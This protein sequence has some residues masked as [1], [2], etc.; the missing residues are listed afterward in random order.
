MGLIIKVVVG[1]FVLL[2]YTNGATVTE[3]PCQ[4]ACPKIFDPICAMNGTEQS[5]KY[6]HNECLMNYEVCQSGTVWSPT[7]MSFC[8]PDVEPFITQKCLRACLFI[9]EPICATDGRINQ[10][11]GN[12]CV[13]E[14]ENCLS[15]GK[16]HET[17]ANDCGF[18]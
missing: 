2:T 14:M 17:R 13:F 11:F 15:N 16:W 1:V 5:Y 9:Y 4:S 3:Q 7:Q 18:E 8:L 10:I 6:F 12:S